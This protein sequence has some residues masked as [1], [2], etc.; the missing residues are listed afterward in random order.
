[1]KL[2]LLLPFA[3]SPVALALPPANQAF[4]AVPTGVANVGKYIP[5]GLPIRDY[6][7]VRI[8]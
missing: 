2:Q 6:P 4:P 7:G 5:S 8:A 3:L 1:M